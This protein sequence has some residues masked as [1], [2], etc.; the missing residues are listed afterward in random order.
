[1]W[2]GDRVAQL[3]RRECDGVR[4]P[5]NLTCCAKLASGRLEQPWRPP[6]SATLGQSG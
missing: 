5:N 1:M 6:T 2:G 3:W 4:V